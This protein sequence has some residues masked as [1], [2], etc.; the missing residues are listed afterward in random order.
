MISWSGFDWAMAG[1][2]MPRTVAAEAAAPVVFR[3]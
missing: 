3:N 2:P 1:K